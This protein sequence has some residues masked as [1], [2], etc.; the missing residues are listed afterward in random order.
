[1]AGHD[2][3]TDM[4]PIGGRPVPIGRYEL[5]FKVGAFFTAREVAM[6][7]SPFLDEIP[8]R[9]RSMSRRDICTCHC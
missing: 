3:R 7:D 5:T 8:L 1:M 2:G 9:F 6:S 4:P